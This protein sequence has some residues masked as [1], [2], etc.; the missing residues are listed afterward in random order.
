MHTLESGSCS[1]EATTDGLSSERDFFSFRTTARRS[2]RRRTFRKSYDLDL[3]RVLGGRQDH[4]GT[5]QSADFKPV[6]DEPELFYTDP[7]SNWYSNEAPQELTSLADGDPFADGYFSTTSEYHSGFSLDDNWCL[8][9]SELDTSEDLF[10]FGADTTAA[11]TTADTKPQYSSVHDVEASSPCSFTGDSYM[12]VPAKKSVLVA[13]VLTKSDAHAKRI[14]LPRVAVEA[15]LSMLLHEPTF[16]VNAKDA[17]G[18]H[19]KF[20]VKSWSNGHNPKPV[21][22]MEQ[23]AEYLRTHQ[24]GIGDAVG[25]LIDEEGLLIEHNTSQVRAAAERPTYCGF[26]A[27]QVA[28]ILS[29]Q[30]PS[31]LQHRLPVPAKV[32]SGDVSAVSGLQ[33]STSAASSS[34]GAAGHMGGILM[35]MRTAGCSRPAGHQGWCSGHKGFKRRKASEAR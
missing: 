34:D 19:W 28:S 7:A 30:H 17:D 12:P 14:I 1:S 26:P 10:T 24:L 16:V 8:P 13:K 18:K 11:D 35:C 4:T 6:L 2:N 31:S 29:K 32:S 21:Y 23:V 27:E 15:N 3:A 9:G 20:V 25:I 5:V 33:T 22:V